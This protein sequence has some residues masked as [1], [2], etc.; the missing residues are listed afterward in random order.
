[1]FVELD[2][3]TSNTVKEVTTKAVESGFTSLG[4]VVPVEL[5]PTTPDGL[6][7]LLAMMSSAAECDIAPI[8][9]VPS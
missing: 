5:A 4:L 8:F 2:T 3:I 9:S 7:Q 6:E 1:M